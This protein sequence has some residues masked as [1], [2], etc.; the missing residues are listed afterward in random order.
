MELWHEQHAKE[1]HAAMRSHEA[2]LLSEQK[3]KWDQMSVEAS[4]VFRTFARKLTPCC[5]TQ[6]HYERCD[7]GKANIWTPTNYTQRRL[8]LP[9]RCGI[10]IG[11]NPGVLSLRPRLLCLTPRR[12]RRRVFLYKHALRLPRLHVYKL[13][14]SVRS[15][16][17]IV[18]SNRRFAPQ[19]ARH[20]GRRSPPIETLL[21]VLRMQ[22]MIVGSKRRPG[23]LLP[24]LLQ[25]Q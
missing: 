16:C 6:R 7:G 11:P 5:S 10:A 19:C 20:R 23:R 18:R 14:C 25:R 24:R 9:R 21:P 2:K 22:I 17:H 12:H 13:H 1:F 8:S 4:V 15:R 3:K